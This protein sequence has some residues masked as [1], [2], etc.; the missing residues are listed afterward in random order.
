M[1]RSRLNVEVPR[2]RIVCVG[3]HKGDYERR[4]AGEPIERHPPQHS[5]LV[6]IRFIEIGGKHQYPS[7]RHPNRDPARD[8]IQPPTPWVSFSWSMCRSSPDVTGAFG[9]TM[10]R[11]PAEASSGSGLSRRRTNRAIPKVSIR[12][13]SATRFRWIGLNGP[14][15]EGSGAG[16]GHSA[17]MQSTKQE[18]AAHLVMQPSGNSGLL[19][20]WGRPGQMLLYCR[21]TNNIAGVKW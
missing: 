19:R 11:R 5:M 4:T 14:I 10:D 20:T 2:F 3:Y 8:V 1:V 18:E 21:A 17:G 6:P 7:F 12:T 16:L 13:S 15:R 9:S